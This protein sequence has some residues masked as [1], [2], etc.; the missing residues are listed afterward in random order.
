MTQPLQKTIEGSYAHV[1]SKVLETGDNVR[2]LRLEQRSRVS[3]PALAITSKGAFTAEIRNV[4]QRGCGVYVSREVNAGDA[5]RLVTQSGDESSGRVRWARLCFCGVEFDEPRC[6]DAGNLHAWQATAIPTA[7]Y[8]VG[9]RSSRSDFMRSV[10]R[11]LTGLIRLVRLECAAASMRAGR[12]RS[13]K[14]VERACRKQGFSW[15]AEDQ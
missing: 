14:E 9:M 5:I 7:S 15:L 4:S 1:R 3:I 6:I 12:R 10:S 2:R 8:T 11:V 13:Q